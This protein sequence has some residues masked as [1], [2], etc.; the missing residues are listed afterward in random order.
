MTKP[1]AGRLRDGVGG[2]ECYT[3][4]EWVLLSGTEGLPMALYMDIQMWHACGDPE[5]P[6]QPFQKFYGR[7]IGHAIYHAARA[8]T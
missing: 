1:C 5:R 4:H 3:G 2:I 6:E 8:T 7:A